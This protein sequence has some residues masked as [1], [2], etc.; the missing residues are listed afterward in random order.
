LWESNAPRPKFLSPSALSDYLS[1]TLRFYFKHVAG[2]KEPDEVE[3]DLDKA[4]FGTLFHYTMESLYKDVLNEV[5][6]PEMF[7]VLKKRVPSK[8]E[9]GFRE[10]LKMKAEDPLELEGRNILIREVVQKYATQML[11]LDSQVEGLSVKFLEAGGDEWIYALPMADG[12]YVRLG[13][14]IDRIDSTEK[15]IRLLDYKT[16]KAERDFKHP[17]DMLFSDSIDRNKT[18]AGYIL[19]TLIYAL[20]YKKSKHYSEGQML[21]PGLIVLKDLFAD[22]PEWTLKIEKETIFDAVT[23]IPAI[24]EGL[25]QI[26]SELF[27]VNIPFV[28]TKVKEHCQYCPYAGICHKD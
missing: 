6:S 12:Q 16:G 8:I 7:E 25:S 26:A 17:I 27:D 11:E 28:Q 23:L 24:E 2:I 1:C 21:Q 14:N 13:G 22:E 9:E 18:K 5:L 20:I 4:S 19:Q 15:G 3:E 10:Q